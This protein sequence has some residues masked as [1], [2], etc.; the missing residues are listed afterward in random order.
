MEMTSAVVVRASFWMFSNMVLS[1]WVP[2]ICCRKSFIWGLLSA[3]VRSRAIRTWLAVPMMSVKR[4]N[5]Q[6][7]CFVPMPFVWGRVNKTR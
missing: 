7:V 4:G 5:E 6:T 2:L 3:K 1:S